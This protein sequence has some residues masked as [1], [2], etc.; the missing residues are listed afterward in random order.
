MAGKRPLKW[1]VPPGTVLKDNKV[2][3]A[4]MANEDNA[5]AAKVQVPSGTSFQFQL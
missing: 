5:F 2:M 3:P 1:L 4:R